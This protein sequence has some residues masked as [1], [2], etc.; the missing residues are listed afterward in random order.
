MLKRVKN[1]QYLTFSQN[2]S[3]PVVSVGNSVAQKLNTSLFNLMKHY[4]DL[5]GLTEVKTAQKLVLE[6]ERDFTKTQE[7]RREKQDEIREIQN[8]LKEIHVELD[9]TSRGEDRYLNLLTQE[10]AII[11]R[12]RQLVD[13][14]R[15]LERSE[16]DCFT[17]LSN[18]L[19]DSHEK[20]RER[21]EKTK[22]GSIIGSIICGSIGIVGGT[23]INRYRLKEIKSIVQDS[24]EPGR[25]QN[26][27]EQLGSAVDNQQQKINSFIA[28]LNVMLHGKPL[29]LGGENDSGQSAALGVGSALSTSNKTGDGNKENQLD[30]ILTA[31]KTQDEKLASEMLDVKRLVAAERGYQFSSGDEMNIENIVY[32]GP[33]LKTILAETERNLE[34][35][36]KLGTLVQ[37]V[38]VYGTLALTLPLIYSLLR[39]G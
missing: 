26:L 21:A 6:A 27:V 5:I 3:T 18:R 35:K 12:E 19:R 22:Y 34:W 25:F 1:S 7:S 13:D 15:R 20:E 36:I 39:G 17:L 10:H 16:R 33:D 29:G 28:E 23:W 4:E 31:L 9:K 2:F 24:T 37:V 11:K 38:A 32:I 30:A 14:F 8:Q